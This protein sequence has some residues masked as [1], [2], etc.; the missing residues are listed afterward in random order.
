MRARAYI[1][2]TLAVLPLGACATGAPCT[3]VSVVV[4]A[5]EERTRIRMEP[6]GLQTTATGQLR[7]VSRE[8]LVRE[9][10]LKDAQG[11]WAPVSEAV[12]RAAEVGRP[13]E[14]CR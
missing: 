14:V 4:T 8:V 7:E 10:W 12:W 5:K 2:L 13:V 6:G 9:Y 3:P 1:G 11:H